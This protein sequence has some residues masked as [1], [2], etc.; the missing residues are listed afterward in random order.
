ML[1]YINNRIDNDNILSEFKNQFWFDHNWSFGM[2]GNYFYTLPFHFDY[3]YEFY[4]GFNDVKSNNP[5]ILKTNPR[6]WYNVKSI[7]LP[8]NH[9][10]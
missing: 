7:D 5:E 3:L 9:K 2:H 8:Y 10:I 6:I 1:N 4:E